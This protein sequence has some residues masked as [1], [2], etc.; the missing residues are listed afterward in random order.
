MTQRVK[1][2]EL[3]MESEQ[4]LGSTFDQAAVGIVHIDSLHASSSR[5]I[6][7]LAR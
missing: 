2:E 4:V 3:R 5:S 7:Y 6:P 1:D